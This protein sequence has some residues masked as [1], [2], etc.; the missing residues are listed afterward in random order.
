MELIQQQVQAWKWLTAQVK[1]V[2]DPTLRNAFMAEFRK[3]AMR[4]WGYCPETAT[5]PKNPVVEL[6]DWEKEFVSDIENTI[7]FELDVG[8]EKRKEA[9]KEAMARMKDFINRGGSWYD[10][11]NDL[12]N[13]HTA[14]LYNSAFFAIIDEALQ[15]LEKTE[16]NT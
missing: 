8:A 1:G 5:V 9:Q 11:P 12:K 7:E 14:K 4:E 16:K 3:R 13:T 10:L 6:E 15:D 2:Q